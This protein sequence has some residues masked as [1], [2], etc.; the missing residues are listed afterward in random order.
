MLFKKEIP[1]KDR[2][3]AVIQWA[4]VLSV[5]L[6]AYIAGLVMVFFACLTSKPMANAF[7]ER[8]QGHLNKYIALG[9]SGV[10]HY[11]ASPVPFL[12]LWSNYEDGDLGEPSGKQSVR[13]KGKERA[14]W[15]RYKWNAFR[16]PFNMGKRTIPFFHCIVERCEIEWWGSDDINDKYGKY[17]WQFV[18]AKHRATGKTYY[19]YYSVEYLNAAKVRVHRYGFK[20]KPSHM[21]VIQDADDKDKAFTFRYQHSSE[22]N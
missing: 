17:G 1:I 13:C 14:F 6:F 22:I 15:N 5:L 21:D 9:S 20:I 18:K 19:G 3:K 12:R 10:W 2:I 16:N 11:K 4:S 7:G 8:L